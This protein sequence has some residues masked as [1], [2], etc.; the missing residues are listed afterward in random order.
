MKNRYTLALSSLL[1]FAACQN[2]VEIPDN[3]IIEDGKVT[4]T[5]TIH[6]PDASQLSTKALGETP[7]FETNGLYVIVYEGG[8]RCEVA[9]AEISGAPVISGGTF[10]Y[11]YSLTLTSS[12]NPRNL[13]FI[14]MAGF[15]P[16]NAPFEENRIGSE[17]YS[18]GGVDAYWQRV[19]LAKISDVPAMLKTDIGTVTMIRN[20][21][22]ITMSKDNTTVPDTKFTFESFKVFNTPDRGHVAPYIVSGTDAG[23]VDGYQN[24]S[25]ADAYDQYPGKI[26]VGATIN[27]Y[28][29]ADD[30][31]ATFITWNKA[32]PDGKA[33]YFYERPIPTDATAAFIIVKGYYE[34][35]S[36]PCYYKINLKD[37]DEKYYALLRGFRF[38]INIEKVSGAGLATVKAAVESAGSGNIST[39]L[40]YIDV[41]NISDGNCRLFVSTTSVT[42]VK[43][44]TVTLKYKFCPT[45]SSLTTVANGQID[46]DD[47]NTTNGIE[48]TVNSPEDDG[49]P[50]ITSYAVHDLVADKDADGYNYITVTTT[51]PENMYKEQIVTIR[52]RGTNGLNTTIIQRDIHVIVRPVLTL[53]AES[54]TT[55]NGTSGQSVIVTFG[56]QTDLPRSIFPLNVKIEP[57][58]LT[59]TPNNSPVYPTG[60]PLSLQTN[61][62]PV[63]AGPSEVSPYLPSFHYIKTV[64]WEMYEDAPTGTVDG[65]TLKVFN[66]YF[67][68]NTANAGTKVNVSC[69]LF[70]PKS[71]TLSN[72]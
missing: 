57:V 60:T 18:S 35:S 1:I 66:C 47:S 16:S 55:L 11:N 19:K 71:F 45:S 14:S 51:E 50:S 6:V 70:A 27:G 48:V 42:V 20:F 7:A 17:M 12:K 54:P 41:T 21:A 34:G 22:K 49:L 15:T 23:F 29:A 68:T 40:E 62:M 9:Q 56:L 53:A 28:T 24:L 69:D 5:V 61:N 3:N 72:P 65:K 58:N 64:T 39:S 8:Y 43:S 63:E 38:K 30:D 25:Y 67:K 46:V 10:V 36:T 37:K 33:A 44:Q 31:G 4:T 26:P 13:H 59:L 52:G 32:N 2:T